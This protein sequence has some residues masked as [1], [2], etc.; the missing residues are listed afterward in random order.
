[1]ASI[2]IKNLGKAYKKYPSPWSRVFEWIVPGNHKNHELKWILKNINIDIS[3]GESVGII[4]I[5]GAG[6]STLL[7]L[8]TGTSQPTTGSINISGRVAAMLEL[9]MGFHPDFTGRQNVILSGQLLGIT[10]DEIQQLMPEIEAFAEIGEYI[11]QPVRVYSSGMQVRLGF[12]VAT[13]IQPDVLI[14]DEALSVGDV[15]FQQKCMARIREFKKNGT[16]ILLVS[17]DIGALS[18]I[19]DRVAVLSQGTFIYDGNVGEGIET[20][21]ASIARSKSGQT[22]SLSGQFKAPSHYIRNMSIAN[23]GGTKDIVYEE[24]TLSLTLTLQHLECFS[25]PHIGIRIQDRY[26]LIAFETN[27]FCQ[28]VFPRKQLTRLDAFKL[29]IRLQ[30]NLGRGDY[31]IAIGIEN[32]G[33]PGGTFESVILPTQVIDSFTVVRAPDHTTLWAGSTNLQPV[34]S[35]LDISNS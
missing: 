30:V 25:D 2:R 29:Q 33:M 35:V 32:G 13:A 27:T 15:Q 19:C 10:S 4:G 8:I 1:M 3:P 31:T 17:H 23:L 14:I 18:S 24:E 5:N 20:Y 11:D 12:A 6:K 34:F 22:T 16:T 7:K 26:G 21:F 28:N 9:G